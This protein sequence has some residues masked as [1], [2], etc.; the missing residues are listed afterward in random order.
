M[1]EVAER[2]VVG[3]ELSLATW[4]RGEAGRDAVIEGP[5]LREV[6]RG[7]ALVL[8]PVARIRLSQGR[9]DRLHGRLGV[10][11]IVPPVRVVLRSLGSRALARQPDR[12]LLAEDDLLRVA[13][14]FGDDCRYPGVEAVAVL[15]DQLRTGC[16]EHILGTR[17]VLVRIGV[18]L[19]DL[20]DRR[21]R[22]GEYM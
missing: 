14:R 11:R 9:T 7:A 2:I 16:G 15:E 21:V 4:H 20:V 18:R 3:D 5:K 13:A 12:H 10:A 19:Q 22:A 1:R 17:L 6:H 8:P